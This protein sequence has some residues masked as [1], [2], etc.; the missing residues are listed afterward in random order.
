MFVAADPS[1]ELDQTSQPDRTK[2]AG[3]ITAVP[4]N[5]EVN[6]K[7]MWTEYQNEYLA[8]LNEICYNQ[9]FPVQFNDANVKNLEDLLHVEAVWISGKLVRKRLT[10][11]QVE[12]L[13]GLKSKMFDAVRKASFTLEDYREKKIPIPEDYALL[14]EKRRTAETEYYE[15]ALKIMFKLKLEKPGTSERELTQ[16]DRYRL[17]R[18]PMKFAIDAV[19]L[20]FSKALPK[21]AKTSQNLYT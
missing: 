11:Y 19:H 7:M 20:S 3:P 8:Q 2:E 4:P 10:E 18:D 16:E 12:Y 6:T 1:K 13:E 5:P 21:K 15:E 9:E 17:E 14:N